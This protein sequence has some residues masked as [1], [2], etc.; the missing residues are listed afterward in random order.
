VLSCPFYGVT[1]ERAELQELVGDSETV[2]GKLQAFLEKI[3]EEWKQEE[4][5]APVANYDIERIALPRQRLQILSEWIGHLDEQCI[6]LEDME[7]IVP[8]DHK[9]PKPE[10]E[11]YHIENYTLQPEKREELKT[12]IAGYN[13]GLTNLTTFLKA[14]HE[15]WE[16]HYQ[17]EPDKCPNPE[18]DEEIRRRISLIED[19]MIDVKPMVGLDIDD[20]EDYVE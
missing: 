16:D 18:A 20:L 8:R 17:R 11:A 3:E 13:E 7:E 14:T 6:D 15:E 4:A 19:W 1:P 5:E 9:P 10:D 12:L 2:K